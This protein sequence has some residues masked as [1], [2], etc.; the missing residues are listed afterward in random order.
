MRF[1]KKKIQLKQEYLNE[2][3]LPSKINVKTEF[4]VAETAETA[5][6]AEPY[7]PTDVQ[8]FVLPMRK[9]RQKPSCPEGNS[10]NI[11]KNY[12]KALCAFA[13]SA[14]AVPYLENIIA[15]N[16]FACNVKP[17][18]FMSFIKSKKETINSIESLRKLL[19]VYEGDTNQITAYKKVFQEISVVFLKYFAVNWIFGGKLMHKNAHLQFRFKMLRRIQDPEHFTYLKT[20]AK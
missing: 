11:V 8:E 13:S 9:P 17:G 16:N 4:S 20:S 12:G 7:S 2:K 15:K 3:A 6:T 10:K 14:I 19:V 5:E 18:G 1:L